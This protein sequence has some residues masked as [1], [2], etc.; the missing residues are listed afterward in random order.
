[1]LEVSI[2]DRPFVNSCRAIADGFCLHDNS[3]YYFENGT[4][5]GFKEKRPYTIP[6]G[7]GYWRPS[8]TKAKACR[9]L[10]AELD[11]VN[12]ESTL[13]NFVRNNFD[14]FVESVMLSGDT[15]DIW[16]KVRVL[17]ANDRVYVQ[18]SDVRGRISLKDP[19][20]RL[21][22]QMQP[23]PITVMP[24]LIEKLLGICD[25]AELPLDFD[26]VAVISNAYRGTC[27][28]GQ[29]VAAHGY[30]MV[31]LLQNKIQGM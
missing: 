8:G 21:Q 30:A 13:I 14:N 18:F 5:V 6:N 12:V 1:M 11:R 4:A 10:Q 28:S 22:T 2:F 24:E 31:L 9:D 27:D 29:H 15:S 7:L 17:V 23:L 20:L 3:L 19:T 16:K 25:A 26:P